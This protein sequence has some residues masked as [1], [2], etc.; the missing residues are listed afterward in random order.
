[1]NPRQVSS[2]IPQKASQESKSLPLN[3]TE[4]GFPECERANSLPSS[5]LSCPIESGLNQP[6]IIKKVDSDETVLRP[7]RKKH[8]LFRKR[9][10]FQVSHFQTFLT[11]LNLSPLPLLT[12]EAPKTIKKANLIFPQPHFG[13]STRLK[14]STFLR[15]DRPLVGKPR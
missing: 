12:A 14:M 4:P 2:L 1:M 6:S 9:R 8:C 5:P 13:R 3:G 15:S 10:F 7:V 11:P